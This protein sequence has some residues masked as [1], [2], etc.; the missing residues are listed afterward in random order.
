MLKAIVLRFT[1]PVIALLVAAPSLAHDV[2]VDVSTTFTNASAQN[3]RTGS[4]SLGFSGSYDIDDSWSVM[5]MALL[6][7][8]LPTRTPESFS[9][10]STVY[11]LN[12]GV[13]WL[14]T[15]SIMTL[16]NL[17][18]S[19]PVNQLNATSLTGPAGRSVDL[20]IASKTWSAGASWH[21]LWHSGGSSSLEHMVDVSLGLNHFRVFQQAQVPSNPLGDFVRDACTLWP[22]ADECALVRGLATPLWQGRIGAGYAATLHEDTDL[23]LTGHFYLYDVSPTV[24]YFSLVSVGREV[25][26]GVPVLPL[27]FSLQPHVA[28]RLGPVTLKL[29]YQFGL[30]AEL[31]GALHALKLR[32]SWKVTKNW[33]LSLTVGAQ[34]DVAA[35][36]VDN[37]GGQVLAAVLY[38]W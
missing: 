12:L 38:V 33:R 23:G 13:M 18:G 24:G 4:V 36:L 11:L 21:G 34:L 31:L 5:A 29:T 3:P 32:A 10:G 2:S 25:G 17:E 30:Y 27:Q 28:H 15:R 7:R 37:Q 19:P 16:L 6:T 1:L 20:V 35:G 14:P 9:S 8:D 26:T 22:T